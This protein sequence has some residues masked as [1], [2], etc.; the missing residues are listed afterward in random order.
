MK[1]SGSDPRQSVG[2][3][4]M[5]APM[6][7]DPNVT[8]ECG[9]HVDAMEKGVVTLEVSAT[10]G[11]EA[12]L[13]ERH[14]EEHD[15]PQDEEILPSLE[16]AAANDTEHANLSSDEEDPD[17]VHKRMEGRIRTFVTWQR[18]FS[19]VLLSGRSPITKEVYEL[20]RRS[21]AKLNDKYPIATYRTSRSAHWEDLMS[22]CFPKSSVNFLFD[23]PKH[24]V[25]TK[26][27]Q[28]SDG[29]TKDPRDCVRVVLPSEWAKLDV[30]CL[31]FY[32]DVFM[33]DC[34]SRPGLLDIENTPIVQQRAKV[35]G[36]TLT[37]WAD[38]DGAVCPCEV[39][40]RLRFP[41]N[42]TADVSEE[43]I[44]ACWVH[45]TRV[46]SD[47][48]SVEA[49]I[50]GILGY[51]WTATP[52]VCAPPPNQIERSW[53]S[54]TDIEKTAVDIMRMRPAL[55]LISSLGSSKSGRA[56]ATSSQYQET[57]RETVNDR[58]LRIYPGDVCA[59]VRP[60][61]VASTKHACLFVASP[62]HHAKRGSAERLVWVRSEQ[63]ERDEDRLP[64]LFVENEAVV[65]AIPTWLGG[66][67]SIPTFRKRPSPNHGRL[68]DGTR[69]VV[70]RLALYTDGFKQHKSLADTRSVDGCYL[71]PLGRGLETRRSVS[72]CRVLSLT[73]HGH[74]VN[75]V[76]SLIHD[77]LIIGASK[78]FDSIDPFG[79]PV[80]IFLD[81]VAMFGDYPALTATTDVRG[82]NA[83]AFCTFCTFRD[84]NRAKSG[85]KLYS[86]A[87]HSRRLGASRSD[88]RRNMIRPELRDDAL[89]QLLGYST[90]GLQ[91]TNNLPMVRL[92]ADLG[93]VRYMVRND[94]GTS[95]LPAGFDSVQSM[96]AAPDH[97]VS[98]L[99]DNTLEV[100]FHA[101]QD[102]RSRR[103]VQV[104]MISEAV[105]NGLREEGAFLKL[106][107]TTFEG[108]RSLAMSTRICMLLTSV[109]LFQEK[110]S[111]TGRP[112]FLLPQKL[113]RF[114]SFVYYTPSE[115]VEGVAGAKALSDQG[116]LHIRGEQ[117]RAARDFVRAA[118]AYYR[119]DPVR[120][121]TLNKPNVHRAIELCVNTINA[122]GHARHCSEMVLEMA[123]RRFKHWLEINTH[124][125]SH[126]TGMERAIYADWQARV[127]SLVR[128]LMHGSEEDARCARRALQRLFLG[129]KGLQIN[130]SSRP[131]ERLSAMFRN[132][133]LSAVDRVVLEELERAVQINDL[134][135]REY[136]WIGQG[137]VKKKDADCDEAM[138]VGRRILHDWYNVQHPKD[139]MELTWYEN[140]SYMSV[141]LHGGR[142][143]CYPHLTVKRNC[144]VSVVL[145]D[146]AMERSIVQQ[147]EDMGTGTQRPYAIYAVIGCSNGELW[148]VVRELRPQGQCHSVTGSRP[149]V[150]RMGTRVRRVALF[151]ECTKRC[152]VNLNVNSFTHAEEVTAGGVY[153]IVGRA[154]G[155]PPHLG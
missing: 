6:D 63:N 40:D 28:T 121:A 24:R 88:H 70:Y 48:V 49:L 106:K 34:S 39:G 10:T 154:D 80:R 95:V 68:E 41:C 30:L 142:R 32:R 147:E 25:A 85:S 127:A 101:L 141:S 126:I 86:T 7:V 11:T 97:L 99:I 67:R 18:M 111:T 116:A 123:H 4:D 60:E 19:F 81:T 125:D 110:F 33:S 102:N 100:C 2:V 144:A 62:V 9:E 93:K 65:R 17:E 108:L 103:V 27:V 59:I 29:E 124:P 117:H 72:A 89:Q 13:E 12:E 21:F 8:V 155:Y 129:E 71:L 69:Y 128:L 98:N 77:D 134:D 50:D 45:G 84:H 16:V 104:R 36:A 78:G 38:Y 35:T 26:L 14:T 22:V 137:P 122:F 118:A 53:S 5:A 46:A 47:G 57:I 75:D 119:E 94:A 109:H 37:M 143:R 152:K 42:N 135:D 87:W 138:L 20:F 136:R 54:L 120:G 107:N 83:L 132:A 79:R 43:S 52:T 105:R 64:Y 23:T 74:S 153:R 130:E 31:P 113:Q 140:A 146:S 96:A 61:G 55:P 56:A 92:A 58:E 150:L 66:R 90:K 73:P 148:S 151:H 44:A 114:V 149:A 3:E 112:V 139:R 82:H 145:S 133:V 76:L 51:M 1:D 131:G 91:D 15:E 115:L